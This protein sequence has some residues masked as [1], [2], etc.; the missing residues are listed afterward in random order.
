MDVQASHSGQQLK[1]MDT[2]DESLLPSGESTVT[3]SQTTYKSYK[4]RFFGL[5]ELILLNLIVSWGGSSFRL[6]ISAQELTFP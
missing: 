1:T 4:R 5:V 2:H 6:M 3:E